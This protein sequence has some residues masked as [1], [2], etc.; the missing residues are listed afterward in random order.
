MIELFDIKGIIE[1][2]VLD[3][4]GNVENHYYFENLITNQGKIYIP[5]MIGGD[6]PGINKI[7]LGTSNSTP[8]PNDIALGNRIV[9]IDVTRDY[10]VTNT[11]RFIGKVQPNTFSGTVTYLE[12]GLIYK[13]VTQDILIT[14][15]IFSSPVFQKS[16]NSLSVTYS[17]KLN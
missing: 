5:Q 6:L 9:L 1:I 4:L 7:G 15:A 14:R 10:T 16:T 8:D 13:S 12:I 2:D 11:V 17:L 3:E